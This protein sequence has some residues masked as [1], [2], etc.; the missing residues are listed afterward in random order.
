L[1]AAVVLIVV[2][3][4]CRR[5][6]S[7]QAQGLPSDLI[8]VPDAQ[9]APLDGLAA[10]SAEAQQRQG[11]AVQELGLPVEVRTRKTGIVFRLVPA[12]S[13][14]MGSPTS[15]SERESNEMQ[16]QVTLSKA[17]YCAMHEVT[18]GQW[19]AL[20]GRNPSCSGNA[21][22]DAP[23]EQVSWDDCQTFLKKLCQVECVPRG[24]YRLLTEAEWE[25]ACRAG[26]TSS[27]CCGDS[28]VGLDR[29]AWYLDS[30]NAPTHPVGQKKANA[31][32]L[33]DMHGNVWEWC[34]DWC[35]EYPSGGVVDP[36]GRPSGVARVFR[37]G[38]C[39][40]SPKGCRSAVR[41]WY[42]P[43]Y[44]GVDVGLRLARTAPSYP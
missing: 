11:Q 3:V 44:R 36:L 5:S 12:G 18:Q 20:M 23:V 37:G 32:G 35:G 13:F 8:E 15:E 7:P 1:A 38:S 4:G 40:N 17:F 31:F 41:F 33:C 27:Y 14:T 34:Q 29:Y 19:Q 43:D 28:N 25:Y 2:G 24:T 9:Y 42:E 26:S 21:G 6:S 10:G 30:S 22:E 16:H 39:F